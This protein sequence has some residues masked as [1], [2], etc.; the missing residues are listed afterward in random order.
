MAVAAQ[1]SQ[2]AIISSDMWQ[3]ISDYDQT[4]VRRMPGVHHEPGGNVV[5][6]L[7]QLTI[8]QLHRLADI[9]N[10]LER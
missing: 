2:Q 4:G 10:R 7:E 8:N 3:R 5:I 9:F 6:A 1:A